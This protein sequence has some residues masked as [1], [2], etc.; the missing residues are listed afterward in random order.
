MTAVPLDVIIPVH[1]VQEYLQAAVA[2][3]LRQRGAD[4]RVIL[5]DDASASGISRA[6]TA[7][8]DPR[9]TVVRHDHNRGVAAARNTGVTHGDRPWVAFLD[10]DDLWPLAR[11]VQLLAVGTPHELRVGHQRVFDDGDDPN[12]ECEPELAGTHPTR[13]APAMLFPR[14]VLEAVGPFDDDLRLGD[15]VD[16][17]ARARHVGIPERVVPRVSLL[18]RAHARNTTRGAAAAK[19]DYLEAIARARSRRGLNA[20]ART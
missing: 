2:S 8:V 6:V 15:F 19:R 12:P 11:T 4:V 7:S 13:V 3:A 14:A 1:D 16:W 5:V 10:A 18:R 20:S 9:V 17:M